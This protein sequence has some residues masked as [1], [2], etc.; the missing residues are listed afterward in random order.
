MR[1]EPVDPEGRALEDGGERLVSELYHE[2]SRQ[3]RHDLEFA[4]RIHLVNNSAELHRVIARTFKRYPG[5][6]FVQLPPI[7]PN[8]SPGFER[9]AALRR[10]IRRF[11]GT[12]L[13]LDAL[14]RLLYFGNGLTGHLDGPSD[15]ILQPLRAAPSGGALYPVELYAVVMAVEDLEPGLYHYAVDRHGMELLRP[16]RFASVLSEAT[17]DQATFSHAAVALILTAVFGR[18]HFKYGERAY[19]F[20]LLEAGHVCQNILLAATALELGAVAVG[21]FVDGEVND[22]LDLDGVD[23]ASIYIVAAGHPAPRPIPGE[24]DIEA[25]M[26][27]LL[28]SLWGG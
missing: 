7:L 11:S 5:A 23:E 25:S 21:G 28:R 1:H 26:G 19:R 2:N 17:S 27:R 12:A 24:D 6:S 22:L 18:S 16:G 3:R 14:A 20:T 9:V 13:G 10:S 15:E 8:D 4:R